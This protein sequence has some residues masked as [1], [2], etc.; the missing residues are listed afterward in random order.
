M[1]PS[2]TS[3]L[4]TLA[5]KC[6]SPH[7]LKAARQD[8]TRFVA[9]WEKRYGRPFDPSLLDSDLRDC[10]LSAS[11]RRRGPGDDQPRALDAAALLRLCSRG[12]HHD[13][14]CRWRHRGRG[15]AGAGGTA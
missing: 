15:D 7:T 2:V 14:E 10:R 6:R 9:W 1:H 11:R 12:R 13:R 4:A 8:L 3:Y 5:D